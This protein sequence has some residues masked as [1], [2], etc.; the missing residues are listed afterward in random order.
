MKDKY[1]DKAVQTI[2]SF[3]GN[4]L[5]RSANVNARDEMGAQ[6]SL[7]GEKDTAEAKKKD[8]I[9]E[10]VA[11]K[12]EEFP[13]I[14]KVIEKNVVSKNELRL[15]LKSTNG[16]E[17]LSKLLSMNEQLEKNATPSKKR[18][19]KNRRNQS[20]EAKSKKEESKSDSKRTGQNEEPKAPAKVNLTH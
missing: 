16:M 12:F 15:L 5:K 10:K 2:E 18:R 3:F 4:T 11:S 14:K 1:V 13:Q 17:L 6:T 7:I 8:E 19:R 9:N 20:S